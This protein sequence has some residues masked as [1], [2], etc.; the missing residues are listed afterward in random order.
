MYKERY[1]AQRSRTTV[2]FE[3]V[4]GDTNPPFVE[5]R[6]RIHTNPIIRIIYTITTISLEK[7]GMTCQESSVDLVHKQHHD[8]CV[9][10]DFPTPT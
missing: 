3:L 2:N 5:G 7:R 9:L 4:G 10:L 8:R 6:G 1:G